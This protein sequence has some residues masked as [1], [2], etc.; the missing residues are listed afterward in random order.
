LAEDASWLPPESHRLQPD[1]HPTPFSA[2]QIR[3]AFVLGRVVRSV[4][5]R[6]DGDAVVR[7]T[8]NLAADDVGG[9]Y[10]VWTE[11]PDGTRLSEPEQGRSTW[12]ELQRHASMPIDATTI[13]PTTIDIPMGRFEGVRYTRTEGDEVDT[14][15]FALS[16]PGAPVRIESRVGGK[17]VFSSIAIS[18]ERSSPERL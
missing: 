1:H 11:S 10:E 8:K 9:T 6:R 17:V 14:F 18:E 4:V 2:A 5:T 16:L 13:E 15:W 12:L 7:A 3:D